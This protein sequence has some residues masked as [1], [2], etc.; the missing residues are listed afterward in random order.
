MILLL[1]T[2]I[3]GRVVAV[4]FEPE[5]S[6]GWHYQLSCPELWSVIAVREGRR[7]K[8][9]KL[10]H[11][12]VANVQLRILESRGMMMKRDSSGSFQLF[13]TGLADIVQEVPQR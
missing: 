6:A 3:F 9:H 5:T 1:R 7:I 10:V 11:F 12:P 4:C 2:S 13:S 8:S